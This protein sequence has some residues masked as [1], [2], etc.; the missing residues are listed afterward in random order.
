MFSFLKRFFDSS[1]SPVP[2]T[3]DPKWEPHLEHVY[4]RIDIL[5]N[6]HW[7]EKTIGLHELA[8]CE[9]SYY[10]YDGIP[11]SPIIR[12]PKA[13]VYIL[14]RLKKKGY[15][16]RFS[17]TSGYDV[18]PDTYSSP[19]TTTRGGSDICG[20]Q[21]VHLSR[22]GQPPT[23]KLNINCPCSSISAEDALRL[24]H[25]MDGRRRE[26]VDA[27]FARLH[28]EPKEWILMENSDGWEVILKK[29]PS[30]KATY[31]FSTFA[32]MI[33]ELHPGRFKQAESW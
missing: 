12:D 7:S 18:L 21:V 17:R 28:S 33:D 22:Q 20:F 8:K 9:E 26:L 2:V 13:W 23:E 16:C 3:L 10:S 15:R 6:M 19:Q 1:L 32:K 11:T 29:C 27:A 31:G 5:D 25:H 14:D 24:G 4:S 30:L